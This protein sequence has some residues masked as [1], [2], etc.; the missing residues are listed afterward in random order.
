LGLRFQ[1]K[2]T[3]A[4]LLAY[5]LGREWFW[6]SLG[7][8]RLLIVF[9]TLIIPILIILV[10]LTKWSFSEV[11]QPWMHWFLLWAGVFLIA[12]LVSPLLDT[13]HRFDVPLDFYLMLAC[14]FAVIPVGVRIGSQ[15]NLGADTLS[16]IA[17]SASILG[18]FSFFLT[19]QTS[20][21]GMVDFS[22]VS[23]GWPLR[24]L[25]L[26]GLFYYF[27]DILRKKRINLQNM[28]W[29]LGP[30]L[31]TIGIFTKNIILPLL[32][33]LMVLSAHNLV[34]RGYRSFLKS[35]QKPL[36]G[37]M[38]ASAGIFLVDLAL[39]GRLLKSMKD[40]LF[41]HIFKA[42]NLQD[43]TFLNVLSLRDQIWSISWIRFLDS[44]FVGNGFGQAIATH[45]I[46]G[47]SSDLIPLHNGYLDLLISVGVL[48][49]LGV[50]IPLVFCTSKILSR[51]YFVAS[52][53]MS[54]AISGYLGALCFFNTGS[55]SKLFY[56]TTV[57]SILI[58]AIAFGMSRVRYE[59]GQ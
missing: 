51:K 45:Q 17:K 22:W 3:L 43:F 23:M 29:L 35:A 12:L 25:E 11:H 20:T 26:F 41:S 13:P 4:L 49:T 40:E 14:A 15:P 59:D 31:A 16:I 18:Y 54:P 19:R 9:T 2:A 38:A 6:Q 56:A 34:L 7:I 58:M 28:L 21:F 10:S 52:E 1:T 39:S 8:P 32:F 24:I 57:T 5:S 37:V 48:G 36:L 30:S 44:P 53:G 27:Q 47:T 55:T 50:A 42:D 46:Y 33:G